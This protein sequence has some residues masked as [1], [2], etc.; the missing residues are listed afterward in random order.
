M[1]RICL[2]AA[3][4]YHTTER[5][6]LFVGLCARLQK[7]DEG[8]DASNALKELMKLSE[9]FVVMEKFLFR[10]DSLERLAGESTS[11]KAMSQDSR[12]FLMITRR[13]AAVVGD[14]YIEGLVQQKQYE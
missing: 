14:D 2:A 7:E 11:K 12:D 3:I 1:V 9:S 5:C 10:F 6:Q 4:F 8:M 13:L